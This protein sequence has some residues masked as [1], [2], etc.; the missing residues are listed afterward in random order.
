MGILMIGVFIVEQ[1]VEFDRL[2]GVGKYVPI[3]NGY[4][5]GGLVIL[6]QC[7]GIEIVGLFENF[8]KVRLVLRGGNNS[9]AL[10]DKSAQAAGM[11]QMVMGINDVFYQLV[12]NELLGFGDNA[13]GPLFVSRAIDDGHVV[14]KL[15]GQALRAGSKNPHAAGQRL[16]N[17][18]QRRR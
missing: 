7:V 3:F 2:I 4:E 8:L 12:G 17:D 5:S 11:V 18:A 13:Q 6:G 16:G 10:G 9:G 1:A 14:L 15:H